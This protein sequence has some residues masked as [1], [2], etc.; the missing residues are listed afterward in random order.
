MMKAS[1]MTILSRFKTIRRELGLTQRS[2]ADRIGVAYA[3]V[4]DTEQGKCNVSDRTVYKIRDNLGV[5]ERWLR[6]GEGNM[7]REDRQVDV[8]ERQSLFKQF[9]RAFN[10]TAEQQ[11]HVA[12]YV[13]FPL[14]AVDIYSE[15]KD[16]AKRNVA[17]LLK[18]IDKGSVGRVINT[19]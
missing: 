13:S 14:D 11:R 8:D 7:F 6:F 4:R 1:E 10:L 17:R 5:D 15:S 18:A 12:E 3:V 2:F 19:A 16:T 9:A